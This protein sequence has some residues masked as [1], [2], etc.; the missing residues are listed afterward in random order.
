MVMFTSIALILLTFF[1]MMTAKA[2]FDETRYGKV[3]RSVNETFG[4]TAGGYTPDG[5]ESGLAINQAS[6]GQKPRP[7]EAQMAQIRGLLAPSLNDERARITRNQGQRIIILSSGL[8]FEGDSAELAPEAMETLRSFAKIM[9]AVPIPIS[10]EGHTD[11]LPPQT[12]G[13]GDNWDVSLERALAVLRFLASEGLSLTQLSAYGYGGGQPMYA[14][15][16][17][18]HR[19][20]NNRVELVLDLT[21]AQEGALK[22]LAG[23]ESLF[24]FD[25]FEFV[26]PRRP[27]QEG[28]VY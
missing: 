23:E 13:V 9:S 19:A 3:L 1:I 22:R 2:N 4:V 8:L 18:A 25:G 20:K 15:N 26:L 17:P 11:N 27:G 7:Y 21:V 14:N 10:V 5:Q 28:E 16:T 6:L 12:E 24:D